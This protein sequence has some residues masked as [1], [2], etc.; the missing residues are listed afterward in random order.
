M[1]EKNGFKVF[2]AISI[3]L[4]LGF[5]IVFSIIGFLWL[6]VWADKAFGTSP[7]FLLTGVI[8]G[9]TITIYETY[10]MLTPLIKNNSKDKKEND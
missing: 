1:S 8:V 10:H 5:V 7:L 2:Y 6:G 4:Q 9:I 3:A